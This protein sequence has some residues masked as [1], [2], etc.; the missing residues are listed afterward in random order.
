MLHGLFSTE[1]CATAFTD[2][3]LDKPAMLSVVQTLLICILLSL[4][5]TIYRLYHRVAG[6]VKLRRFPHVGKDPGFFHLHSKD[7]KHEFVQNAYE[8]VRNGYKSVG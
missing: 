2:N 5:P 7:S 1:L 8:I 6:H 3:M 4:L